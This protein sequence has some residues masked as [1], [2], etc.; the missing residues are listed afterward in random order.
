MSFDM[1]KAANGEQI[2]LDQT[3]VQQVKQLVG[4]DAAFAILEGDN[5]GL[6]PDNYR[7]WLS[8]IQDMARKQNIS[9]NK[10]SKFEDVAFDV[11]DKD[12]FIDTLS[13]SS[14]KN[15]QRIVNILWQDHKS[16]VAHNKL[17]S[18]LSGEENEEKA[19]VNRSI[20]ERSSKSHPTSYFAG[21]GKDGTLLWTQDPKHAFTYKSDARAA[22]VIE[23]L[24][25]HDVSKFP[26]GKQGHLAGEKP[27]DFSVSSIKKSLHHEENEEQ[28]T[29]VD[30]EQVHHAALHAASY[31]QGKSAA[32]NDYQSNNFQSKNPYASGSFRYDQWQ[33]GYEDYEKTAWTTV[34]QEDEEHSNEQA[35]VSM[36]Q[37]ENQGR[38]AC[39]QA[40]LKAYDDKKPV[41]HVKCPHDDGS[42]EHT[43]WTRG[44][45]KCLGQ[46][47]DQGF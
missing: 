32:D 30:D 22:D 10:K 4:H 3:L 42:M 29:V 26:T 19:M 36:Q 40:H 5:N 39:E 6:S 25:K 41:K 34:S 47:E 12:R 23:K 35:F 27:F 1:L 20:I 2:S 13:G 43:L 14:E 31:T 18:H 45:H 17:T 11:L 37:I 24:L 44:Y 7:G 8:A 28:T 38:Q 15:K 16:H 9:I 21:I 46:F 33:Q